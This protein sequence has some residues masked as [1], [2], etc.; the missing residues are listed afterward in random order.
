MKYSDA[1]EL[2]SRWKL[3]PVLALKLARVL[4]EFRSR[5][6]TEI[7]V[8]SGYRSAAE[9]AYLRR[10]GRPTAR[11][12][13]S[14]HRTCP[15]T[16]ADVSIDGWADDNRK[17]IFGEIAMVNGLRW[18]G[19]APRDSKGIPVDGEWAHVDLGPRGQ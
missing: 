6:S 18:G 17:L 19:G 9:Q 3:H 12:D 5:T 4:N 10:Q 16:G 11:D 8:M 14:T 1:E 7:D 2:G 15:A 13:L